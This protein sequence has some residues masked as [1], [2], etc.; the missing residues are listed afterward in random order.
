MR[1][2][3]ATDGSPSARNAVLLVRSLPW[4]QDTKVRLL[5]I[6]PPVP[7]LVAISGD[8][9]LDLDDTHERNAV[10]ALAAPLYREGLVIDEEYIRGEGV[11][12]LIVDDARAWGADLIVSGSR[13]HGPLASLLLGSVA[14]AVSERAPCPILVARRTTCSRIVFAEDGSDGAFEARSVLA[15]WPIFKGMQLKVVSVAHVDRP[16][17]SGIAAAVFEDARQAQADDL[18]EARAAHEHLAKD[19]AEQLRLAGVLAQ[20]ELRTGDA[21]SEIVAAAQSWNAD[22]IVVGSRGRGAIARAVLGSVARSVLQS[23]KCSVLVIRRGT[24]GEATA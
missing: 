14:A 8:R 18:M 4:P 15:K 16:L 24:S 21:A 17:R 23:A 5:E 19:S 2:L 22:L 1:V 9:E 20:A 6:F 12:N 7:S 10:A 3:V 11:A 13:G